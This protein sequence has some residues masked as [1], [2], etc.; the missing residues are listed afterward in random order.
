MR[1]TVKR[2]LF[3]CAMAAGAF[4]ARPSAAD[5]D[6]GPPIA[7]AAGE[8][9]S[10][11]DQ[12]DP[13]T[14]AMTYRF[15]FALPAAR[16]IS[17]PSLAL[18]YNS[19][20]RD[21]DAGYSWG[22]DLPS[23]ELRP[24]AGLARFDSSGVPLPLGRERYAFA[25]Q[26]L[27]R[28]CIVG[29]GCPS[30][31]STEGHPAWATGWGYYRLQV[32]GLF[33]R[34]YMSGDR[35]TWRVQ[36]KGGDVLEL[37][38]AI[39][40]TYGMPEALEVKGL[41]IVRWRPV[42]RRDLEH[43]NNVVVYRWQRYGTR[44][45]LYLTDI[46]DTPSLSAP[47]NVFSFAH[48]AQL[49]W[50]GIAFPGGNHQSPERATPDFRLSRV[51]V[52]SKSWSASG[53]REIYRV[54]S[55][56]Y[57]ADRTAAA[58]NP[59]TQGPLWHHSF[60]RQIR[61]SGHC[62][63]TENTDG[64]MGANLDCDERGSMPP[65]QFEYSPGPL[66]GF[67]APISPVLAGPP[68]AA[69]NYSVLP[70]PKTA[71]I[72]DFDRDGLPDVVQSWDAPICNFS[73][74]VAVRDAG[75][76]G[77]P[78]LWCLRLLSANGE[79]VGGYDFSMHTAR[80]ILGYQNR[81]RSPG[82]AGT[83]RYQCMD[84]G[85]MTDDNSVTQLSAGPYTTQRQ[86]IAQFLNS[87]GNSPLGPFGN[88]LG[89]WGKQNYLP[90]Y[91]RSLGQPTFGAGAEPPNFALGGCN[92]DA[93]F[94]SSA[95]FPRWRWESQYTDR[96][97]K[98]VPRAQ[99]ANPAPEWFVDVDGD[100]YTDVLERFEDGTG[101]RDFHDAKVRFTRK[102][103]VGDDVPQP[104]AA[105]PVPGPGL[106]PF[107]DD[108]AS[109]TSSLIPIPGVWDTTATGRKT[110]VFY[111]DVNGDGLPDLVTSNRT[112]S[113]ATLRVRSGD[114]TG[115]FSCAFGD[116]WNCILE[117]NDVQDPS[118]STS[119]Y[120]VTVTSA[121]KPWF[122]DAAGNTDR[123]FY[124]HDVTGD[125]LADMVAMGA[126]STIEVWVNL[127]GQSFACLGPGGSCTVGSIYDDVH[128]ALVNTTSGQARLSFADMNADGVDD[129]VVLAKQGIFYGSYYT[130]GSIG[131]LASGSRPGQ[132][133]RIHNGVGATTEVQYRT[134]QDLDLAATSAGQPWQ[135]HSPLVESVVA[136]ITTRDTSAANGG[137]A[138]A[139]PYA[140]NR[141]VRYSYREP[142]Y[143]RWQRKLV[144]FR[145]IAAQVGDEA[146]V[147]ETTFW[148][149]PCE[150]AAPPA[151]D[152][153]NVSAPNFCEYGS[154]DE[155]AASPTFRS[156]VGKPVRTDR[157]V[158][159]NAGQGVP[160]QRLWSRS[161]EYAPPITL[162]SPG[163]ERRVT[164]TYASRV[165]T[166]LYRPGQS[167]SPGSSS[168]PLAG[169]DALERPPVQ[170][171]SK[172]LEQST[173]VD[174][175]GTV[176]EQRDPG[177]PGQGEL[178]RVVQQSDAAFGGAP[179]VPCDTTWRCLPTYV[180]TAEDSAG[181]VARRSS[182]FTYD[183]TTKDLTIIE[184]YLD[185]NASL[186]RSHETSSAAYSEGPP[187][188]AVAGWKTLGEFQ[189]SPEGV[190]VLAI[191]A[192]TS[193]TPSR[194]CTRFSLDREYG[195]FPQITSSFRDGCDSAAGLDTVVAFDR[196]FGVPVTTTSPDLAV[197][198]TSLDP[199]G[200]PLDTF[201]PSPDQASPAA[202]V[203][204]ATFLYKDAAPL[205]Y[206][207]VKTFT[208]AA[209]G[210]AIR[211]V[212]ITNGLREP[213][214]RFDQGDGTA[215]N[216]SGWTAR[217]GAG[218][219]SAVHRTFAATSATEPTLLAAAATPISP[220]SA[221][222]LVLSTDAFGR[223]AGASEDGVPQ[224]QRVYEPL[225][226]IVR[227]AEQ[228]ATGAGTHHGAFTRVDLTTRGQTRRTTQTTAQ[229][230]FSTEI[231]Y[232]VL[233]ELT[234][235]SRYSSTSSET[236]FRAFSYDSL[237]RVRTNFEPN[238]SNPVVG[239][240]WAYAWDDTNRLVGTSD[241]LGCGKDLYYDGLGRVVGEDFSPC[242]G[243]HAAYTPAD[244]IARTNFEVLNTYDSYEAGQ[245]LSDAT[246]LD[247]ESHASG[248]LVSTSDRGAHTRYS[249]DN[250]GRVRRVGRQVATPA[251]QQA[252]GAAR[253]ALHWYTTRS[254]FDNADRPTFR[255]SGADE[256][257]F[258]D[259]AGTSE[260]YLYSTRGLLRA[261]TSA[262][263]GAIFSNIA[264][265]HDG[266]ANLITYGDV[267]Q[268]KAQFTYGAQ[269][270]LATYKIDRAAPS[271][272]TT[273]SPNYTLPT[274]ATKQLTLA[275]F[276][277]AYDL[278]GNPK[279]VDDLSPAADWQSD[280]AWPQRR[281]TVKV[282]DLYRV[283][284]VKYSYNTV[285]GAAAFRTPFRAENAAR[286]T[287]PVPLQT[288]LATRV[289]SESFTYDSL[290]NVT[291]SMD[292]LNAGYDRSLG[293]ITHG[294]GTGAG[295]NQLTGANG[296]TAR[297]D[298]AGNL[299]D[300]KV[301][302]PGSC[303]SGTGNKCAQ[304]FVYDWD[305]VGQLVRARRWDY[306]TAIP[307][308]T[309]GTL[310]PENPAWDLSYAYSSGA[311]VLKS[312]KD[313]T[314]V[315]RHTLEIFSTLRLDH[316][317]FEEATGDYER[318]RTRTH[319]YLAGGTGHVF[320]DGGTLPAPPGTPPT[321]LY[322]NIGDHLGSASVTIEHKTSEVMERATFMSHGAIESDYRPA[323]WA[324]AREPYKFTGKEEDIEV[325]AMYFGARYYQARLG[326]FMSAD[327]LAIH[328]LGGDLNPYAYV[329]GRVMSHVD[330]FGLSD[331]A[332]DA[333]A[334]AAQVTLGNP[335][336]GDSYTMTSW[337][338]T[339]AAR[340]NAQS[341]RGFDGY[342]LAGPS[343]AGANGLLFLDRGASAGPYSNP[344]AR[345][346]LFGMDGDGT[347]TQEVL[348]QHYIESPES[349]KVGAVMIGGAIA[350]S[351][352]VVGAVAVT[353][354]ALAAEG[355][356]A[357]WG[358]L[359]RCG[360]VGRFV[361]ALLGPGAAKVATS[362]PSTPAARTAA[363]GVVARL[364][365]PAMP[366]GMSLRD[367]GR[368]I[369]WGRG[370]DAARGAIPNLTR[371]G[372]QAS[373]VTREIA[374]AWGQFYRNEALRNSANPSAMGRAELMEAAARLLQ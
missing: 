101:P 61:M 89:I 4:V 180:T 190:V 256:G 206:V 49:N 374:E 8:G 9:G 300:L 294:D 266:Q 214:M 235:V 154:D 56:D 321:R 99:S 360:A 168:V 228:I 257:P 253:Y 85:S 115:R 229:G 169:G 202:T 173:V 209:G 301:V 114:G 293:A 337:D 45:L 48:H 225:A 125:G 198:M 216:I 345:G 5:D 62:G 328:A 310:P 95:F 109:T 137:G 312:A 123:F 152:A 231:L 37:G 126:N 354:G 326:R 87:Q 303:P 93:S 349:R 245:L 265:E 147:T 21:R 145:K 128:G 344:S 18:Q 7:P 15:P 181:L 268:S 221:G 308:V 29:S 332:A 356:I 276:T 103:G 177:D 357:A 359:Q 233:G 20:T 73:R 274:A 159:G 183:G 90:F 52:A 142:A 31:A 171:G 371:E 149:G 263:H 39:G 165:E 340:E 244:P 38:K 94:N 50:D 17:G 298:Y 249:Y 28:I 74:A 353:E 174:T 141:K 373:G 279:Q 234:Q 111:A 350:G 319:V 83:F 223:L 237:G 112:E 162:L 243:T 84:A 32:E 130:T 238:T 46:Y 160:S 272:W 306:P 194:A 60:L 44:G 139:V 203:Q 189:Y 239:R 13:R 106:V 157:Y 278:V 104:N 269:R 102:F 333:A 129:I 211:S 277:Y 366:S 323:R 282:D 297:Y 12:V 138:L 364:P 148:F 325:G 6:P 163:N 144:G 108:P 40:M 339:Q 188:M 51:A 146:A 97:T 184:G 100:G 351:V 288:Q 77:E 86:H 342:A 289:K 16:G 179:S 35:R 161:F 197:S 262:Q 80:P 241:A 365:L 361:S 219:V 240:P 14:G 82:F 27:V 280:D 324:S 270:R 224:M 252:I 196:G 2:A 42:V 133:T 185:G 113:G 136:Q 65:V 205:S 127:D 10:F 271:L 304:W 362:A 372:L 70:Y 213:V 255:T 281:R 78:E 91:A 313:S 286:D 178:P 208:A 116:P 248:R 201:A 218:R 155:F 215:W 352:V 176:V 338:G 170:A 118:K 25:G 22:L 140:I 72:V 164:F 320:Y 54:Y 76:S 134:I 34:F 230:D 292:D 96:W 57:Y 122:G 369:G 151:A 195:Q 302:R 236:M 260:S 64:T 341:A 331:T 355:G 258:A 191:G 329:R 153:N 187:T 166:H 334:A 143:D 305:E 264:Y 69:N 167:T 267:A 273:A 295:P 30:E 53:P 135:H 222:R 250:R 43:P 217:D 182:R 98:P 363:T 309:A 132:L 346:N 232:D 156:W 296:V 110:Q 330:H 59:A 316:D 172:L 314:L 246:F 192:G 67:T 335:A 242:R 23:I 175:N 107:V 318:H 119:Y 251:S 131:N 343:T 55:L 47:T 92:L 26:P 117:Y 105:P 285:G 227:D 261:V 63:K 317:T 200:R 311:R 370:N 19:S 1:S 11:F 193:A 348:A 336:P 58:Y 3:V 275:S 68:G 358:F 367:F 66:G 204:T 124:L 254:N 75:V 186:F 120:E 33:A 207:D 315:E 327:P 212:V 220:T 307:A 36:Y 291:S 210:G 24:L 79:E 283:F 287:S 121:N 226:L 71:A 81:G 259:G 158:P 322:L 150:D 284:D 368:T 247:E 199:F 41:G 299:E 347:L 290:G 88:G